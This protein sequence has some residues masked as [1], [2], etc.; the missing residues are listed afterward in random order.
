MAPRIW[1]PPWCGFQPVILPDECFV[2]VRWSDEPQHEHRFSMF[3]LDAN[4]LG[5]S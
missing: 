2:T 1:R 5:L 4:A 3:E